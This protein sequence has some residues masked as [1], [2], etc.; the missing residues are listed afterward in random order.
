MIEAKSKSDE[1]MTEEEP[2]NFCLEL[3][4]NLVYLIL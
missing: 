4:S 1:A 2:S 3:I